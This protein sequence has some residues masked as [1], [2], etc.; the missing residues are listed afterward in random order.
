[1]SNKNSNVS[2]EVKKNGIKDVK[3][4]AIYSDVKPKKGSVLWFFLKYEEPMSI[5][6]SSNMWL[7]AKLYFRRNMKKYENIKR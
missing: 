6:L 7:T 4:G 2:A 3:E 1:M 5:W